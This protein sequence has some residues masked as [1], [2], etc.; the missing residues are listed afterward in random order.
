M[1]GHFFFQSHCGELGTSANKR[2]NVAF[3]EGRIIATTVHIR[4]EV[5]LVSG[6]AS[7]ASS[8]VEDMTNLLEMSVPLG[9]MLWLLHAGRKQR[10]EIDT[11]MANAVKMRL[12]EQA[13]TSQACQKH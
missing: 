2:L 3:H 7:T 10:D 13:C 12:S 11:V 8:R 4:K 9:V 1:S 6:W 5:R